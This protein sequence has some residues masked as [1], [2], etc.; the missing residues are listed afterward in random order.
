MALSGKGAISKPTS[1]LIH[2]TAKQLGYKRRHV[3]SE[4]GPAFRNI[5]I[6][7]WEDTPNR[8]LFSHSFV[9]R[10]ERLLATEGFRPVIIHK[11]PEIDDMALYHEIQNIHAGA[12][13]SVHYVNTDL[14]DQLEDD[15]IPV[16]LLNNSNYQNRYWS[17]LTDDVQGAFEGTR[18][19]IG[20]GHRKMAYVEYART[21]LT[22]V[23]KDRYFG[24]R[25]ALEEASIPT[26]ESQRISIRLPDPQ[27]SR[28]LADAL[29]RLIVDTDDPVTALFMHDDYLGTIVHAVLVGMGV[30]VPRDVSIICPGDVMDYSEP[31]IPRLSTMQIDLPVM[32]GLAWDLLLNRLISGAG[33]PKVLKTTMHLVDRGSCAVPPSYR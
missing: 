4:H 23:V 15:G 29:R 14:F 31:F 17:V 25:Q 22:S 21:N 2:A 32:V 26:G 1:D 5:G 20:L 27:G 9:I 30:S 8:W 6:I 16:I 24:F 18:H 28:I 7:Q 12:V 3:Q 10:L 19:L 33:D 11:L 13:F